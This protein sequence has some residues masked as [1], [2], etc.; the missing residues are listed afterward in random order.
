MCR[1]TGKRKGRLPCWSSLL[2]VVNGHPCL[3]VSRDVSQMLRDP[4]GRGQLAAPAYSVS[5]WGHSRPSW[6]VHAGRRPTW[7]RPPRQ[8]GHGTSTRKNDGETCNARGPPTGQEAPRIWRRG[9]ST[10][11]A[12]RSPRSTQVVSG[13][14]GVPR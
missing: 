14:V 3:R 5:M 11:K 6:V 12:E 13:P 10:M 4:P 2:R 8:W 1:D 7:G 9:T